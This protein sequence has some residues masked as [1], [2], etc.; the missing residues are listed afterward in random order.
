[1]SKINEEEFKSI[2]KSLKSYRP[3][4]VANMMHRSLAVV[5]RAKGCKDFVEYKELVTSEHTA[6]KPRKPMWMQIRDARIEELSALLD[7]KFNK[8]KTIV[9]RIIELR[10]A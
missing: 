10:S 8:R 4:Q 7:I 2:K 1:M 9:N 6:K 3:K 5:L